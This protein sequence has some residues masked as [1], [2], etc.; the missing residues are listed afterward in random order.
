[1]KRYRAQRITDTL[2]GQTCHF[3]SKLEWRYARYLEILM[4]QREIA[5]W[6][7]EE[8]KFKCSNGKTYTPDFV[9][10]DH[11]GG[12][13]I[14]ETKGPLFPKNVTQIRQLF[15]DHL[16]SKFNEYHL[17]F[18]RDDKKTRAKSCWRTLTKLQ[19][20]YPEIHIHYIGS[21]LRTLGLK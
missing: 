17:I 10:I 18:D 16:N 2:N 15:E 14:H 11:M 21:T 4:G 13:F 5:D 20:E 19:M 6:R 1:M 9:V 3:R 8:F 12:K 7:Y